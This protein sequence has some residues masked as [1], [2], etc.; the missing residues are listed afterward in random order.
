MLPDPTWLEEGK[1]LG[2]Q[3]MVLQ[4]TLAAT[5]APSQPP[6]LGSSIITWC[7]R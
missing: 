4:E 7:S 6:R 3:L 1:L 5:T 2:M